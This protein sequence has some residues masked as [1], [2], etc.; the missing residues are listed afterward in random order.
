MIQGLSSNATFAW[1][2][3]DINLELVPPGNYTLTVSFDE[4]SSDCTFEITP[5]TPQEPSVDVL[6]IAR[7]YVEENY[8]FDYGLNDGN[9]RTTFSNSSG[10]WTYPSASFRVPADWQKPGIMVTVMV[11]SETGE[12]FKV[13]TNWSK[14]LPPDMPTG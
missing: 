3:K 8:G 10:S 7:K 4:A 6:V 2:Q 12:I 1:N 5:K 14:S 9:S 13:L 11:N